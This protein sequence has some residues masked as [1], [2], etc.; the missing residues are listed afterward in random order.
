MLRSLVGSEMC[1]R[2]SNNTDVVGDGGAAAVA[3][4]SLLE[5]QQ[6][7]GLMP[8]HTWSPDMWHTFFLDA[9]SIFVVDYLNG[10]MTTCEVAGRKHTFEK[11]IQLSSTTTKSKK[12]NHDDENGGGYE[13]EPC[14]VDPAAVSALGEVLQAKSDTHKYLSLIHI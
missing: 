7:Q 12:K 2:D 4:A 13:G 3:S 6:Q 11:C 5:D 8:P 14:T 10:V 9:L 1:I